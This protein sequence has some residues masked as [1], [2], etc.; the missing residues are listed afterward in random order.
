MIAPARQAAYAALLAHEVQGR[1][2]P[3]AIAAARQPL[4]DPRDHALL[5]ELELLTAILLYAA[6]RHTDALDT[7]RAVATT[8]PTETFAAIRRMHEAASLLTLAATRGHAHHQEETLRSHL[9][10]LRHDLRNPIGTIQSAAALMQDETGL[11]ALCFIMVGALAGF[12]WWNAYPARLFMGDAGALP[13]GGML[14]IV[15]LQSGW[16]LLLPLIGII[17]VVEALSVIIQITYFRRTGGKRF[18][19]MAPIH[20]HFEKLGY[21]ET[22]IAVRFILITVAASLAAIGLAALD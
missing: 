1:D 22:T 10:S 18:F 3:S 13:L 4:S 20:H 7:P 6:E 19:R 2:L 16:W 17:Y 14:A 11:A 9:R 12:L 8:P 5:T 21:H 15:A